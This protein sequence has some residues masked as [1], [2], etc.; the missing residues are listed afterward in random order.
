M[1]QELFNIKIQSDFEI[2]GV[3]ETLSRELGGNEALKL[4]EK[5]NILLRRGEMNPDQ[6]PGYYRV[7]FSPF[8]HEE[9]WKNDGKDSLIEIHNDVTIVSTGNETTYYFRDGADVYG[10]L[11]TKLCEIIRN[12]ELRRS[13]F[14]IHAAAI[15]KNNEVILITGNKGS[16][17]SSAVFYA[18]RHGWNVL[19]DE[20]TF[21]SEEGFRFLKRW[22][23]LSDASLELYFQEWKEFTCGKIKSVL[24]KEYKNLLNVTMDVRQPDQLRLKEIV[25]LVH[26]ENT[27]ADKDFGEGILRDNFIKGEAGRDF[28]PEM[29]ERISRNVSVKCIREF[30]AY[31]K[32]R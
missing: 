30:E 29:F 17:K 20:L 32:E 31:V 12:Y 24:S 11:R 14:A 6:L 23:T 15:E 26:S 18:K 5:H 9:I 2:D 4:C 25:V 28:I 27:W 21:C 19:T 3:M 13:I 16:G 7:F 10:Y 22:P 8:Y 1:N